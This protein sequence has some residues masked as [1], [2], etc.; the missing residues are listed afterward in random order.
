MKIKFQL[1]HTTRKKSAQWF[2]LSQQ[3]LAVLT[4]FVV[5]LVFAWDCRLTRIA[6]HIPW[7][8]KVLSRTQTFRL[9]DFSR[10]FQG[11]KGETRQ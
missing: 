6:R 11:E 3:N 4:E 8:T 1:Y 10:D 2:T 9:V 5:G 7:Q